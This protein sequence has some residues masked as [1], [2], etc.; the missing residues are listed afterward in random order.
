MPKTEVATS[1][2]EERIGTQSF[3]VHGLIGKGS[4]GEVYFV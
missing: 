4:F 3:T 1:F 2:N